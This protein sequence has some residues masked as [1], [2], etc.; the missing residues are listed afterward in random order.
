MRAGGVRGCTC[1]IDRQHRGG[2]RRGGGGDAEG[3][4]GAPGR[5]SERAVRTL[6]CAARREFH[7]GTRRLTVRRQVVLRP[8]PTRATRFSTL[9]PRVPGQVRPC[10]AIG[11]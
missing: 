2:R 1:S 6:H 4:R 9:G 11:P 10:Y 3:M 8:R 7:T 5:E